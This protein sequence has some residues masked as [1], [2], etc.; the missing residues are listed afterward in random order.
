M[1]GLFI[2]LYLDEDVDVLVAELVQARGFDAET[3]YEAGQSGKSDDEQLMYATSQA[4][5]ILTHNRIDFESLARKH[6]ALQQ[7]HAGMILAVRRSPYGIARRLLRLM[8]Q[9][10]ADEMISQIDI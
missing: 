10:T 3:T 1:N 4:R 2:A 7:E 9:V 6:A 5:V 8:N